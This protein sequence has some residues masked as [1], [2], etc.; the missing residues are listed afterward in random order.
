MP[1]DWIRLRDI[2]AFGRHGATDRERKGG[3]V[4]EADVSMRMDLSGPSS[5]DCLSET[6]DYGDV[7]QRVGRILSGEPYR[8]LEAVAA[9]LAD[10]LL[11]SYPQVEQVVVRLRKPAV[12][13]ALRSGAVEVELNRSRETGSRKTGGRE[14]GG[15]E[16]QGTSRTTEGTCR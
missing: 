1:E 9:R 3:Q 16:T 6:V 2:R 11:S 15:G 12:A 14:T 10:D 7:Q 8:L 13:R 4:F 5:T